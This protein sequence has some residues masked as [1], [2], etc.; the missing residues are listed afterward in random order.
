MQNAVLQSV[1]MNEGLENKKIGGAFRTISEV[2][3][4]LGVQQHVLR[5]W[6][7]K[8]NQIRPMKRGGGRRYYRA[9]DVTL[10]KHIHTLLYS[11]G[12]TIKGA[13]KLLK[14]QSKGAIAAAHA[15]NDAADKASRAAQNASPV[16]S[17]PKP[18]AVAA[19]PVKVEALSSSVADALVGLL[20][21]LKE[22]RALVVKTA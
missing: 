18:V 19:Q 22:L 15:A 14:G 10:L 8:F 1:D 3:S 17:A 2:A 20:V 7:T 21:E 4:D 16:T 11:E 9:E 13:Q 12:Y 5:F 6:E